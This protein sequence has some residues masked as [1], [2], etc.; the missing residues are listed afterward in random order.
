MARRYLSWEEV[1]QAWQSWEA[2]TVDWEDVYV[3]TREG[4]GSS[5]RWMHENPWDKPWTKPVWREMTESQRQ[6]ALREWAS[7]RNVIT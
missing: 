7:K 2:V 3:E 1:D 4:G 5:A 6:D